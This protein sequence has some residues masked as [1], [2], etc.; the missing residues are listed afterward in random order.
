VFGR[1][2]TYIAATVRARARNSRLIAAHQYRKR[3][4]LV[5]GAFLVS[6]SWRIYLLNGFTDNLLRD[7]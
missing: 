5:P 1:Y 4:T 6:G 7:A 3:H 2:G